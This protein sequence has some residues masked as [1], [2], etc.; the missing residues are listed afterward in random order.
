MHKVDFYSKTPK[1]F[2]TYIGAKF[3]VRSLRSSALLSLGPKKTFVFDGTR[4]PSSGHKGFSIVLKLCQFLLLFIYF[5]KSAFFDD[6]WPQKHR[7]IAEAL[8]ILVLKEV[9]FFG[10]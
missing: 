8:F 9:F 6:F 7:K 4:A 10:E 1:I 2:F 5:V 3:I